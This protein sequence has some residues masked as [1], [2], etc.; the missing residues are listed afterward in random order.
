MLLSI[1]T[2]T[3]NRL[4]YLKAMV[5]SARCSMP[6]T[7]EYEFVV[8]DGG[9]TDGTL[10]WMRE[11]KDIR[12][13]EQGKLLGAIAAFNAAG[14]AAKGDYLLVAND[15]IEFVGLSIAKGLAYAMD[16]VDV[17]AVCFYQDRGG[18]EWHV[19]SMPMY[20]NGEQ[21]WL[22]YMQVGII[23]RWL[24]DHCEGWG[25]WGGRTYGGD[26][27]LTARVYESG[28]KVIPLDGC[29]IRDKTPV[30]ELR[31]INNDNRQPDSNLWGRFPNG[32]QLANTP[33]I[34]NPLPERKRVLY[35][36]IIESGHT[37]QKEQK[38][39]LREALK[40]LGEVWEVDYVY[41]KESVAEAAE[42][43]QPHY[44]IT[45][46]HTA[47]S[48]S[49]NEV[50]RLKGACKGYMVNWNGD[51][52]P[53]QADPDM[54]E[55]L[56]F[57]DLHTTVNAALLPRYADCGIRAAY[58]QNSF[59]PQIIDNDEAGPATDVLFLGNNYT[60]QNAA[61]TRLGLAR[62]LKD[63]PYKVSI[64]GRG[65]PDGLSEGESL[66]NFRKSGQLYRGS[67]IAIADNQF[68]E[69]TGFAS[70]RMFMI[71][72][73]GNTCMFH[74]RVDKMEEL[75]GLTP[76]VHFVEWTTMEDLATKVRYYM[77][78]EDERA[79]IAAAGTQRVRWQHTFFDRVM[80]LKKMLEAIPQRKP[81]IS[82]T[83]IVKDE[84]ES[85]E[86]CLAD[87]F[88]ADEIIIV[89]TGSTDRT[90]DILNGG[91]YVPQIQFHPDGAFVADQSLL[92]K[93]GNVSV[94]K[95]PWSDDFAAARNF[96]KSKCTGDWVFWMDADDS[97][98][99][100]TLKRLGEFS[101]WTFRSLGVTNPGAFRF[102][103]TNVGKDG[104]RGQHGFQTR[105]F[106][107]LPLI[108]W[109]SPIHETVDD[110]IKDIGVTCL[111]MKVMKID[112][113]GPSALADIERHQRRNLKILDTMPSCSWRNYQKG[114]SY[115]AMERW[116]DA[117]VWFELAEQEC[118]DT[119]FKAF[120]AFL[121]GNAFIH[122]G[123][124][125]LAMK[126]LKTSDFVDALYLRAEMESTPKAGLQADLYRKFLKAPIPTLFPTYSEQWRPQAKAKLLE[127]HR[128]ELESLVS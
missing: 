83:M 19:E 65:Y 49:V 100:A 39:G 12:I 81:T 73:A 25:N 33:Q 29:A 80:E 78:H 36:P 110:S 48:A 123:L 44:I 122:M 125:D 68:F 66:Y 113:M 96:G 50:K 91:A 105:L 104:D 45:Q 92:F 111:A 102:L 99:S 31:R 88:W 107:N 30:D 124:D 64:Y 84:A 52:W 16:N 63:L 61:Q 60:V 86:R 8:A 27:Y 41:A 77:E 98:P 35:A 127:W 43:W 42:A 28:Y 109:R 46:F 23:P 38:K 59:E 34:G 94:Y 70:D 53:N 116:G 58:W 56:R 115:A 1:I 76:G 10:Q 37:I 24:W 90:L 71:L 69:A 118:T 20:E 17:G 119:E 79:A 22:P 55:I 106:K 13:I 87:L 9:S 82:A 95:F 11:Q 47:G 72:A 3:Y 21:K 5:K 75:L 112:H 128:K 40:R 6:E 32:F 74:Q 4:E 7:I 62:A 85:I 120:L 67:K 103:V 101:T 2:G 51:V 18:K 14:A 89:D 114:A 15:D 54:M 57:Y 93:R 117:V 97:I 108:E 26:N 121:V 126:K